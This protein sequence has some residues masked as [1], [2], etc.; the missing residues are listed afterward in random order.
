ME[1]TNKTLSGVPQ[2]A[3]LGNYLLRGVKV[4]IS[5]K[6]KYYV[7]KDSDAKLNLPT[8]STKRNDVSGS[9]IQVCKIWN[10]TYIYWSKL[11]IKAYQDLPWLK[12]AA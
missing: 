4:P 11:K 7:Y 6:S 1:P 12:R 3:C 2:L 8:P 10:E 5:A 9:E